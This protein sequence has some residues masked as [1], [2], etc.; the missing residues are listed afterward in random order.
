MK[1]TVD[2]VIKILRHIDGVDTTSAQ[3][4]DDIITAVKSFFAQN[5][6]DGDF[7]IHDV[8]SD[9]NPGCASLIIKIG[10]D[11]VRQNAGGLMIAGH[12]DT[13]EFQQQPTWQS[14]PLMVEIRDGKIYRRGAT[15]MWGQIATVFASVAAWLERQKNGTIT[16]P[17]TILLS[18]DEETKTKGIEEIM[19][20]NQSHNL[21]QPKGCFVIEPTEMKPI[22]GHRGVHRMTIRV[23]GHTGHT[24]DAA[25]GINA[26]RYLLEIMNFVQTQFPLYAAQYPYDKFSNPQENLHGIFQHAAWH[27]DQCH[28]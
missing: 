10:P 26:G 9:A 14:D 7:E 24:S 13:V 6:D 28:S 4:N 21:F 27:R 17:L 16:E 25:L 11:A 3:P 12:M 15:D 18:C 23:N 5:F 2:N 8:P 19:A 22:I 1:I 20:F